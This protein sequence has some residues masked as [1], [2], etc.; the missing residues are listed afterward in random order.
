MIFLKKPS[1]LLLF[2]VSSYFVYLQLNTLFSVPSQNLLQPK[3]YKSNI[4][5]P[6]T[7]IP[8]AQYLNKDLVSLG[9]LLFFDTILSKNHS[10]SCASCHNIH[11]GG[12]DGLIVSSGIHNQSGNINSPTVLNSSLNFKQF[13]D[14]RAN[15]LED[16]IDGPIN[17][18]IEMGS[19]WPEVI[20][21]LKK[22]IRYQKK[23]SALYPS[24]GITEQTIKHAIATYERSLLT[25]DS[26]FDL[27]LKGQQD[28]LTAAEKEGYQLFISY[29]CIA[30]HQGVN[31][32][33]NMF[34]KMGIM[35]DYF[36]DRGKLTDVDLGRYRVTMKEEHK[37]EFKVPSL[38]NIA[39][40]APY[41]HDGQT[42]TLELAVEK[43]AYYQIGVSLPKNET[44]LIVSFLKTL[45]GKLH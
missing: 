25:P 7:P 35:H 41:F 13:W 21:K 27:F 31:M 8:N 36:A 20:N 26:R 14:G 16:Q 39:L 44:A 22:R 24:S 30:C 17:S 23:F 1:L 18:P 15:S 42:K 38:R 43:M 9:K 37:Y 40:T 29:G 32:G 5:S 6:I 4:P 10:V 11:N 34:E 33:G 3:S 19:S 12:V 45:T 28:A 2:V